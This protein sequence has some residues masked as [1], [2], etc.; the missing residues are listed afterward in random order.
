MTMAHCLT[1]PTT[2]TAPATLKQF[3]QCGGH[4]FT[5]TRYWWDGQG[6]RVGITPWIQKKLHPGEDPDFGTAAKSEL[7]L[8]PTAPAVY[9]AIPFLIEHFDRQLPRHERNVMVQIKL[10]LDPEEPWHYGYENIRAFARWHF[11]NRFPVILAAHVPSVGGLN[12]YGPHVHCIVLSRP[13]TINGLQGA[14][15]RLCSDTGYL[16]A[17]TAWKVWNAIE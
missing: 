12:G 14:C 5:F 16:E 15:Y 13:I 10:A 1:K 7:L 17:L 9:A 3:S 6:E 2:I 4:G 8:P 11:A